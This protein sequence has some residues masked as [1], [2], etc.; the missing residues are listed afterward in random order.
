MRAAANTREWN[1]AKR[2]IELDRK[3]IKESLIENFCA[4][5]A[6]NYI[7]HMAG[8]FM[9]ECRHLFQSCITKQAHMDGESEATQTAIGTDIRG[10]FLAANMLLARAKC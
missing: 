1:A 7:S 6:V 10:R 3:F 9:I 4:F 2:L 5:D 8:I